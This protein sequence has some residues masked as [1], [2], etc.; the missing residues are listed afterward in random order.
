MNHLN[1]LNMSNR[2]EYDDDDDDDDEDDGDGDDDDDENRADDDD[3]DDG[4]N[5][6]DENCVHDGDD[7]D[8]VFGRNH[9]K[10]LYLFYSQSLLDHFLTVISVHVCVAFEYMIAFYLKKIDRNLYYVNL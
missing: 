8:D 10:I 2:N 5:H 6:V 7:D 9:Q 1:S 4:E 3:D